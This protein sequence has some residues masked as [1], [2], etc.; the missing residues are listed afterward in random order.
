MH[1]SRDFRELLV[2]DLAL[3]R[4][5]AP[6]R[7]VA[8]AL[9]RFWDQRGRRGLT[10]ASELERIA[11]LAPGTLDAIEAEADRLVSGAGGDARAAL[12]RRG[13]DRSIHV[14]LSRVAPSAS[15]AL[16]EAGAGAR[17]PLHTVDPERY[18][19]FLVAGEGGMGV[20]Y[21]A[22]DT[23]LNRF[24]AFKMVRPDA[25][26]GR[27]AAPDDPMRASP[28]PRDTPATDAFE[29]L[30]ARFL[31]EAW[32]T[33]GLEHPG[34]VPVYELG[35]T[36]NGIPYYTMRFVRGQRSLAQAI[37]EVRRAPIE[38]RLRLLEPFLKVCDTLAY[39]HAKHVI[40]RD[41]K[42][43]NVALGEFGEVVLLDW[44]LAKLE[45]RE[46]KASSRWQAR[47]H[48]Y[49]SATDLRT[50]ASGVGT[51]GYMSPEAAL[52]ELEVMDERSDVYSLGVILFEILTGRLP[53]EGRTYLE[54]VEQLTRASAPPAVDV[55]GA[56][57]RALSELTARAL[58]RA[59]V[60]RPASAAELATAVRRWQ[61]AS[62]VDREVEERL[63]RASEALERATALRGS[64][65]LASVDQAAVALLEVTAKRP[66]DERGPRVAARIE[67]LRR[68]ALTEHQRDGVRRAR[69]RAL[70]VAGAL[71]L[72]V[73]VGW[74][75]TFAKAA[76]DERTKERDQASR[77]QA[78]ADALDGTEALPPGLAVE[79]IAGLIDRFAGCAGVPRARL[80]L[81]EQQK[82]AGRREQGLATW[83]EC[84]LLDAPSGASVSAWQEIAKTFLGEGDPTQAMV[85]LEAAFRATADPEE[86]RPLLALWAEALLCE[87][88]QEEAGAVLDQLARAGGEPAGPPARAAALRETLPV[89]TPLWSRRHAVAWTGTVGRFRGKGEGQ[90]T[91]LA[92]GQAHRFEL[93][94]LDGDGVHPTARVTWPLDARGRTAKACNLDR[95]DDGVDE[96]IEL[97]WPVPVAP[98]DAKQVTGSLRILDL[99]G[100][101]AKVLFETTAPYG[102]FKLDV[103]DVDGD[104]DLDIVLGSYFPGSGVAVLEHLEGWTFRLMPELGEMGSR[105]LRKAN[106]RG[107][108][109][110]DLT[111]D[112]LKEVILACP[113]WKL[114]DLQV[115]TFDRDRGGF[116]RLPVDRPDTGTGMLG[117]V[118]SLLPLDVGDDGRMDVVF[119]SDCVVYDAL[120]P[121][122]E[123]F[124]PQG[125]YAAGWDEGTQSVRVRS[126]R[127]DGTKLR[128]RAAAPGDAP[129]VNQGTERLVLARAPGGGAYLLSHGHTDYGKARA[130]DWLTVEDVRTSILRRG[131]DAAPFKRRVA[132]LVID[133][134]AIDLDGD[135]RDEALALDTDGTLHAFG[136]PD[137]LPPSTSARSSTPPEADGRSRKADRLAVAE[138]LGKLGWHR[139]AEEQ[140]RRSLEES[141]SEGSAAVAF[142]GVV[143]ALARQWRWEEVLAE[144]RARTSRGGL[145]QAQYLLQIA[146]YLDR[147]QRW[148][149]AAA[150][151]ATAERMGSPTDRSQRALAE[152][153]AELAPWLQTIVEVLPP[154][155][156]WTVTE[157]GCFRLDERGGYCTETDAKDASP[158]AVWLPV[159]HDGGSFQLP[160]EL[161]IDH[162]GHGHGVQLGFLDPSPSN[163]LPLASGL[164]IK[165]E[166]TDLQANRVTLGPELLHKILLDGGSEQ[167][168]GL[169]SGVPYRGT[170]SWDA[171][172]RLL[173]VT[174]RRVGDDRIVVSLLGRIPKDAVPDG[175]RLGIRTSTDNWL[176]GGAF[177]V[178]LC[179]LVRPRDAG[180]LLVSPFPEGLG[181]AHRRLA[182]GFAQEARAQYRAM[183]DGRTGATAEDARRAGLYDAILAW[184]AHPT[185]EGADALLALLEDGDGPTSFRALLHGRDQLLPPAV[186]ALLGQSLLR[187]TLPRWRAE[188]GPGLLPSI[189]TGLDL[190]AAAEASA[191]LRSDE[192]D[193]ILV[194]GKVLDRALAAA[195]TPWSPEERR[196]LRVAL[197][198]E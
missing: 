168:R 174:L 62:A 183:G 37:E 67:E 181:T 45:G 58:A 198:F 12:G 180:R 110:A 126:L 134:W 102:G 187:R 36:A 178:D 193:R 94:G 55:D 113:E 28:P 15:R 137:A 10:F 2:A 103:G 141:Q 123:K 157:A 82:R 194:Y 175:L 73:A 50:L 170:L 49:R 84:A 140:Y 1:E 127:T 158:A 112:G 92:D 35:Q 48:E 19:D 125:L 164:S 96:L 139:Q 133:L 138:W 17:A 90:E 85:G 172:G 7:D 128:I 163:T 14:A 117:L 3:V 100:A 8:A 146:Q 33:G 43:D 13:L 27:Q 105:D 34:I 185:A 70:S 5:V 191:V 151:Y 54:Y 20:V 9:Q 143:D 195:P 75:G 190:V 148:T 184:G 197:D 11:G 106:I 108:V 150:Q 78:L 118:N 179:D 115:F 91:V 121:K 77:E 22:L 153:A 57:P 116:K 135:E 59:R 47:I 167:P 26:H 109:I 87:G 42:P 182:E 71:V 99:R 88:R 114:F 188:R 41:L 159:L 16:A 120:L 160:F 79:T 31:Q 154:R 129:P 46:D 30:K 69:R 107:V 171:I 64:E 111:G 124:L 104:E 60:D 66:T 132:N 83:L 52:G 21:M 122:V 80:R 162:L 93:R 97:T 98:G 156:R 4:G 23:E 192:D 61:A 161:Q 86:R 65:R 176:G 25:G 177:R 196:A 6:A 81:G 136:L 63:R 76:W 39:A 95:D 72:L 149:E 51:P 169:Q 142:G 32:V 18:V 44:G 186:G 56:V 89:L 38:D 144:L 131:L 24:V 173:G 74:L 166:T 152:R 29:E 165:I 101:E 145:E 130:G 155:D 53:I 147:T 68:L 189:L 40:H 119:A